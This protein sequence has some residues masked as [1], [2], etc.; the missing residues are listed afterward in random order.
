M[1]HLG[2][3]RQ[4]VDGQ[5][6]VVQGRHEKYQNNR[7]T[8]ANV[9]CSEQIVAR[10][11]AEAANQTNSPATPVPSPPAASFEQAKI[12]SPTPQEAPS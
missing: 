8:L 2:S 10:L 4:R 6:R 5:R 3:G 11:Q 1:A 7:Q 9:E 12:V